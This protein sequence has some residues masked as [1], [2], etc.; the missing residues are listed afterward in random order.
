MKIKQFLLLPFAMLY[1]MIT[2]TRNKLFD[3]KILPSLSYDTPIISVGNLSAGGTGKTPHVSY[4]VRLLHNSSCIAIL[5]RGYKRK[6]RGFRLASE[7]S[8][9]LDI[10]DEPLQ[11]KRNFKDIIVAVDESRRS[12]IEILSA[13]FPDLD[14]IILDDAF[15][16]RYVKPGISILTTDF[17]NLYSSDLL[18]PSG[19]LREFAS[20]ARRADIIIVTKTPAV[21]SPITVRRITRLLKPREKQHLFFS[22]VEYGELIPF[23]TSA[24]EYLL[25]ECRHV[26]V[27][28]GIANS[29]PLRDYLG[30]VFSNV[31][32]L[33]FPDHHSYKPRDIVKVR[34]VFGDILSRNKI[35]VTTEKDAMRLHSG[36][37]KE[38]LEKLPV[39][40]LPIQVKFHKEDNIIFDALIKDYVREYK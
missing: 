30:T 19:K 10:G 12:G 7:R 18:L 27:F 9:Y 4:I 13:H 20:G 8:T 34:R 31:K 1:G 38:A 29:Y 21:L 40:Y 35:I 11:Y 14:V 33:D 37:L 36:E 26:L 2:L 6:T 17:H 39:F 25:E 5:S 32:A 28:S 22:Y 16:H 3:W 23:N 24:R 15:Q